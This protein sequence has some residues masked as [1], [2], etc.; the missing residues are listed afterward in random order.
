MSLP[1]W[2]T[3]AGG[4]RADLIA[5]VTGALASLALPPLHVVPVL[6]LAFPILLTQINASGRAIVAA[7]RGWGFGF[8][9]HL[10]GL[11]WITEAILFEAARFWWL[12]P[13]AVPALAAVLAVFIAIPAG[14]A[15]FAAN[16]Q[17]HDE[18]AT[19]GLAQVM[20]MA[21]AWVL[22]DLARQF[23]LTGFPW[24]PLGSVW[25][26]PGLPGDVMLQPAAQVSVH[27]LTLATIAVACA[28][29]LGWRGRGLCLALFLAWIGYGANRMA[30][31]PPPD[32]APRI[33]LVQGNVPQGQKWDP[34]LRNAV[35]ERYLRLTDEGVREAGPGP[36]VVVWPETASPFLLDTAERVAIANASHGEPVLAGAVRFDEADRPRNTLFAVTGAGGVAALYDKWHLVPFGEYQPSWAQVGIQLV[37]G[38][39]FAPGPGPET[40]RI[41]GVPPVGPLICY[42]AIFPG[43]VVDE[44]D[45]PDWMVNVTNDAWFGTSA[46][47]RQ[48]LAAA[49]LRAVEEGLPLLRAANT[50]ITVA[51]DARGHE[52]ARLGMEQTGFRTVALPGLLPRTVFG[53]FGLTVPG[54]LATGLLFVGL[55]MSR[56]ES[57]R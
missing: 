15:W 55:L 16:R 33:V 20:T 57:H 6:L 38:G 19:A 11:Y 22:A 52:I 4:L 28:P 24:N 39:G 13:L 45:R 36:L 49:R 14:I 43:Q 51:F 10:I 31:P 29:V 42:E 12:V 37:P 23:V 35:F 3:E 40:L 56:R 47:P 26:L 9:Y 17:R 41:P 53:R 2:L 34:A 27:G 50:G 54:L 1:R 30:A 46:G 25:A 8:G 32:Q 7:R 44:A 48:H 21:G 18:M 5:L